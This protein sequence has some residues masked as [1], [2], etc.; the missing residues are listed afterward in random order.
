MPAPES[1]QQESGFDDLGPFVAG[2]SMRIAS[3]SFRDHGPAAIWYRIDRPIIAGEPIS[4]LMR[5][6]SAAD[7]CSGTSAVL[8]FKAW[9]FAN[10]D[11]TVALTRMPVGDW[12]RVDAESR[13]GPHGG[14][15][16]AGRLADRRGFFGRAVQSLVIEPASSQ[17]T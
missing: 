14:G 8:D 16:A 2:V 17:L 4:P 9:C 11:L 6:C 12:I 15:I 13:I 10:G 5:A 1:L 3:G 7:F